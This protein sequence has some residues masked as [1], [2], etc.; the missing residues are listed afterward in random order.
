MANGA[1]KRYSH[2]TES[3][4]RT[5]S[6]TAFQIDN[7][8]LGQGLRYPKTVL[9]SAVIRSDRG[10]G[11][12]R[13][14]LGRASWALDFEL[15]Y[16]TSFE[17]YLTTAMRSD[18]TAAGTATAGITTTVVA[19]TTN[20]MA[21]TGVGGS[22][23]T[24]ISAGDWVKVSGFTSGYTANNGYIR[25]TARADDLLTFGEAVD[26]DGNSLL[27]AATAQASITFQRVGD[28]E[29]GSTEKSI[30]IEEAQTD[31]TTPLY[32][33]M[34]GAMANR[35]SLSIIPDQIVKGRFEMVGAEVLG[36]SSST[37]TV[38]TV[39]A[40]TTLP[41]T[42]N[43][44][45]SYLYIDGVPSAI[46]TRLDLLL[47]NGM[48]PKQAVYNTIPY[49][50][51]CGVSRLTGTLGIMFINDTYWT[52]YAAE[53]RIAL[54]MKM[55]DSGL[56]TGYAIDMPSVFLSDLPD[57]VTADDIIYSIPIIVEPDSSSGLINWKISKLA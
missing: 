35:F 23:A 25:C 9:E 18:M 30:Q 56:T 50:I 47:D 43:D 38:S 13:L 53:T 55:L 21:G 48:N 19:G 31:L 34:K 14:G 1:Q 32:R 39:A 29:T 5:A 15:Q 17:D 46:V 26:A 12:P 57:D 44:T 36:P 33:I 27:V 54:R 20:T 51:G 40:P 28:W 37:Y 22:G 45:S 41:M 52:K 3:S 7:V 2:V 6:G 42:A 4:W 49:R 24:L 16:G 8:I 11:R 10:I